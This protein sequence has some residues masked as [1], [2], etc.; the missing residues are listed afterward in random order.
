MENSRAVTDIVIV[1]SSVAAVRAAETLRQSGHEGTITVVGAEAVMPYDKPPLSKKY[2]SGEVDADRIMLR[3]PEMLEEL[4][5]DW[6]LGSAAVSLDTAGRTVS[7]ADGS[8]VP[9]DGV[10]LATG[11]TVRTLPTVP[12]TGGVHVLRSRDDADA[13]RAELRPGTRLVVVGAGFIGLEAAATAAQLG[14]HVTV[15]E[16]A[17]A[18]LIRG[19]GAQMGAAVAAVHARNGVDVRCGVSVTGIEERDGRVSAVTLG[20]GSSVVAD[21]VLVGIGVTPATQWLEGSGLTLRDG[22]VC[23]ANLCA[24]VPGVYAAGDLLRWPNAM[25]AHVEPDMRVEHWTNAAEQGAI[26]AQNLLAWSRGEPQTP[27]SAV[28]FFWSDQFDARIQFLGRSHPDAEVTVVAGDPA[29]GRFAA[30]YVLHD[31]LIAVLGVSMP[32]M[33]M[34]SRALLSVPTTRE[35][36]LAHFERLRNPPAPAG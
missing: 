27:Y 28:P 6:R 26:A 10:I 7:L 22:V 15:L 20:D 4:R 18:P 8:A 11:G 30:M 32:K 1:G 13:L 35:Q 33:V 16:G 17:P 23:D 5:I 21:A 25:F 2:L 12:M 36:A 31:R 34:P 29:E 14:A 3:R 9:W 19:L 24:G